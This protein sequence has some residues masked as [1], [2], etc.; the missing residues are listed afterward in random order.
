MPV[1]EHPPEKVGVELAWRPNSRVQHDF[2]SAREFEALYGGA[3]GGGKSRALVAGALRFVDKPSYKGII[4]RRTYPQLRELTDFAAKVYPLHGGK[5]KNNN[6]EWKFPS[7]AQV[8]FGHMQHEKDAENYNGIQYQYIGF[9]QLEQFTK[10]QYDTMRSCCRSEDPTIPCFIRATSNPGGIGHSWVKDFF[11]E[12]C[13]PENLGPPIHDTMFDVTWQPQRAGKVYISPDGMKRRFYPAKVF[14]NPDLLRANPHYVRILKELPQNLRKAY[15]DGNYDI[16]DGQYFPEWDETIH[17]RPT[18]VEQE[19]TDQWGI[20]LTWLRIGGI[21]YGSA[22]P[23][24]AHEAAIDPAN[25]RV[26][27]YRSIAAKAWTHEMQ[28]GWLMKGSPSAQ[29]VADDSCFVR[30]N[31]K[32]AKVKQVSDAELWGQHG[33]HRVGPASKGRRVPG[34]A[35]LRQFFRKYDETSAWLE[36]HDTAGAR[37]P[38]G[39]I[40]TIPKMVHSEKD[41]EDMETDTPDEA[42]DDACD[43]LRYMML[44]RPVPQFVEAVKKRPFKKGDYGADKEEEAENSEWEA[45]DS[46][47][48]PRIGNY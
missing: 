26:I 48:G 7:G 47:S 31:E 1:L 39:I 8:L 13:R 38:Y 28:A 46:G 4:F 10:H 2:L 43:A 16:F 14:D 45:P 35:H 6:T 27:V 36:I 25:G 22:N 5:G 17:V 23:W 19:G 32:D 42:R 15:L 24:S 9:D 11:I 34:W 40:T 44:H 41:P 33:F 18:W 20:P 21:D 30:G 12:T 29:Y 37:G 3:K